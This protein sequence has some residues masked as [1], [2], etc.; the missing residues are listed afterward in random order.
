[1][2]FTKINQLLLPLLTS[3]LLS[4][5]TSLKVGQKVDSAFNTLLIPVTQPTLVLR[6]YLTNTIFLLTNLPSINQENQ[7]LKNQNAALMSE[8]QSLRAA[9]TDNETLK[10]ITTPYHSSVPIR[11]IS[12]GKTITATTSLDLSAVQPDQPVVSGSTL[13][14]FVQSVNAPIIHIVTLDSDRSPR[15]PV[16]TYLGQ[17]GTFLFDARVSQIT[18]VPSE[19]P[20]TLN[21]SLLTQP[22]RTLPSGLVIGKVVKI[23]S[24]PQ[25]PLQKAEIKLD[26]RFQDGP[27]N[28][29]IITQP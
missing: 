14:G 15:F 8:N 21:D 4:T 12:I 17:T 10:N 13:L 26:L 2:T 5:I 29:F 3:I 6:N 27:A 20:L 22:T 25:E 9:I 28:L 1:M 24:G 18:D 16:K 11:V 19:N 23:L 7:E